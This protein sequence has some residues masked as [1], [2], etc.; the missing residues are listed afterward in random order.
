MSN[1][2]DVNDE[3]PEEE[4]IYLCY[5]SDKSIETYGIENV[6]GQAMDFEPVEVLGEQVSVTHWQNLPEG[7]K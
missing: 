4:G 7:P 6:Y 3:M 2:I 5:F 1:W